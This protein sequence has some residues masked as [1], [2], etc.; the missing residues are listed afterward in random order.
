YCPPGASFHDIGITIPPNAVA[1]VHFY[2]GGTIYYPAEP[3]GLEVKFGAEYWFEGSLIRFNNQ[4]VACRARFIIYANGTQGGTSGNNDV[5]KQFTAG[6]Q[7]VVQILRPGAGANP[8][9]ADIVI[10]SRWP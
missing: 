7:D 10:D 1:D 9:F 2:Q 5:I 8:T 3:T 4:F 6:G